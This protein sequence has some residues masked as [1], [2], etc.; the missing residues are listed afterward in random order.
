MLIVMAPSSRCVKEFIKFAAKIFS[1]DEGFTKKIRR[2]LYLS[3][4]KCNYKEII[5]QLL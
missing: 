2:E 1:S 3:Q 4:K 5:E